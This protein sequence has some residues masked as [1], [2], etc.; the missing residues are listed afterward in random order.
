MS[1]RASSG[2]NFSGRTTVAPI[3]VANVKVD[4][5]VAAVRDNREQVRERAKPCRRRV[6]FGPLRG[7]R[8]PGGVDHHPRAA[9][10]EREREERPAAPARNEVLV[11]DGALERIATSR[12]DE[13]DVGFEGSP[14][15]L[16]M[17]G[18]IDDQTR[19]ALGE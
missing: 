9:A 3:A 6:A 19:S 4:H 11:C 12:R 18:V 14:E 1:R 16:G 7:A 13:L 17:G 10:V 8:C 2:S 5:V 15:L